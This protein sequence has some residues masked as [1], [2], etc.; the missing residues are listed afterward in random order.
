VVQIA[1]VQSRDAEA[2]WHINTSFVLSRS[3]VSN[4][5]A[6]ELHW[7]KRFEVWAQN[8]KIDK[9]SYQIILTIRD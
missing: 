6:G 2:S 4:I 1:H 8:L 7:A 3:G 5:S 9:L